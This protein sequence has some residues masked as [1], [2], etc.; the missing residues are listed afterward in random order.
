MTPH[1]RLT[2]IFEGL[3]GPLGLAVS[4]GSDSLALLFLA[5]DW[6]RAQGVALKV[7]TVNHG[8]RPEAEQECAAVALHCA[9]LGVAHETLHWTW[10]KAG[11]LQA[12]ARAGRYDALAEWALREGLDAVALGHTQDDVAETFLMRLARGSG[13]TGLARMQVAWFER[14]VNWRR[15]LLGCSR[16]ELREELRLRGVDWAEDSSNS[17]TRFG[18][19]KTREALETLESLGITREGL[20]QT[21]KRLGSARDALDGLMQALAAQA[22]ALDGPDLTLAVEA[23]FNAPEET[24]QRL[25]GEAI[26]WIGQTGY[27]PRRQAVTSALSAVLS[28]QKA[29]LN[30][31]VIMLEAGCIRVMR[32]LAAVQGVVTASDALWDGRFAF[33]GPHRAGLNIAALGEQGLQQCPDWRETGLPRASLLAAPAVWDND[34]LVAAPLAGFGAGW[35]ANLAHSPDFLNK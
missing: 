16:E 34:V 15:P 23:L 22:V 17:D 5:A 28:G 14:G 9:H 11:N 29:T 4:G 8:L 30:G 6:A 25:F 24:R 18:R 12:Q 2:E 19:V 7:A 13:V 3:H 26:G 21:A 10:D 32:E 1:E 27:P 33:T 35:R 31:C 20:A